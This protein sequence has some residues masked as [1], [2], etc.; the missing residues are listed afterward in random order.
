MFL[1]ETFWVQSKSLYCAQRTAWPIVFRGNILKAEN[2][3]S[4]FKTTA[5]VKKIT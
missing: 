3:I 1:I 2:N 5:C 4:T